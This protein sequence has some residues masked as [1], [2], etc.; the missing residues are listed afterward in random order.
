MVANEKKAPNGGNALV[1]DDALIARTRLYYAIIVIA[2][3]PVACVGLGLLTLMAVPL[4]HVIA[5]KHTD[6]SLTVS[7]SFNAVLTATTA[8]AGTGLAIQTGRARH[9]R[10]RARELEA[11]IK[12][13][14]ES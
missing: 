6:F 10:S 12:R 13:Q 7:I 1:S 9:H 2:G 8:L 5:G 4:A 11:R 14:E 3:I